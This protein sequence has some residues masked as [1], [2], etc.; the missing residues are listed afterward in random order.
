M[1]LVQARIPEPEYRILKRMATFSGEPMEEVIRKA[2]HSYL[3]NDTVAPTVRL[4][5]DFP[6]GARGRKG[7]DAAQ[8][9]GEELYGA[10]RGRVKIRY[11]RSTPP[12]PS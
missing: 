12:N 3:T 7:H 2:V 10:T 4:V 5:Q 11:P 9:H 8:R 1:M 6:L